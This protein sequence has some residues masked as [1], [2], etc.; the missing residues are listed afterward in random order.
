MTRSEPLPLDRANA[1]GA[2]TGVT[3]APPRASS[4]YLDSAAADVGADGD[5]V[6]RELARLTALLRRHFSQGGDDSLLPALA[7]TSDPAAA[8][9]ARA[10]LD[11]IRALAETL[12]ADVGRWAQSPPVA[13]AFADFRRETMAL[14]AGVEERL[15]GEP[16]R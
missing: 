13:G 6:R 12:E 1:A 11:Q 14:L 10:F 9:G 16:T 5:A 7:D 3:A 4:D 2:G 15:A 8:A